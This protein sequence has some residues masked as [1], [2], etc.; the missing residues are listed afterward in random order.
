MATSFPS[1]EIA[2]QDVQ[3]RGDVPPAPVAEIEAALLTGGQDPHYAFGLAS[4]L[5][6]KNVR[7]DVIGG[8]GVDTPGMRSTPKLNFLNLQQGGDGA[9]LTAKLGRVLAFYSR[10]MRYAVA[11]K[12]KVLHILWNNKLE[13][14]DRT[15][16]M[17]YLKLLGKKVVLTAHNVN[18]GRRDGKDSWLNRFTL[19]TQYG[20]ADHIFVH[21]E[22]MKAEL[23]NE[24]GVR[25]RSVTVIPYGINN[26]VP[27]TALTPGEAKRKLGIGNDERT[28][29]FYGALKQY[30]GVE[31]LVAAFLQLASKQASYRLIIAGERKKGHEK[32]WDDIHD[33]IHR[34]PNRARV[35]EK[36][37]FISDE[38]TE[39]Y[40][41]A[42]DVAVL[43]Y[44][45]IFQSGI[46]F[47][48]YSFGLP[49]IVSA[50]GSFAD[51]IIEG[52]TGLVCRPRD[53]GDLARAIEQYFASDLF[54]DLHTRR[55]EIRDY[56]NSRHSWEVVGDLTRKVYVGLLGG[57]RC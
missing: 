26:A 2:N 46:L 9:G 32:Y 7:L 49:V 35:I 4:A 40:F 44:T 47:L 57:Q 36:I 29:L 1:T 52:R 3:A 18:A 33:A 11:G 14:F 45:E 24:F 5:T 19:K 17:L 37:E 31:Y 20:M 6:G 12:P 16:L 54:Q 55:Q 23:L 43:P 25:E 28:I 27:D 41:K 51:D 53:A 10:I 39:L 56:A 34:D 13:Y 8:D 21:T 22:A 48:A 50:V 38:E 15:G 42:A 30:K